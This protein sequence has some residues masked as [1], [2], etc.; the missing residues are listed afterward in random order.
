MPVPSAYTTSRTTTSGVGPAFPYVLDLEASA[1]VE[2]YLSVGTV[3]KLRRGGSRASRPKVGRSRNWTRCIIS[4]IRRL[5]VGGR[6]R[7]G[8]GEIRSLSVCQSAF[9]VLDGD[10]DVIN[11]GRNCMSISVSAGLKDFRSTV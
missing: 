1:D 10:A 11:S 8:R 4:R 5:R 3:S 6:K 9:T 7:W 2:Q